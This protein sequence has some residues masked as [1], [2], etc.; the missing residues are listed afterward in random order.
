MG[1]TKEHAA[2]D[3]NERSCAW[4]TNNKANILHQPTAVRAIDWS[5]VHVTVRFLGVDVAEFEL[6]YVSTFLGNEVHSEKG[7]LQSPYEF[8]H[9]GRLLWVS[10]EL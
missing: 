5:C 8:F 3:R 1:R 2:I 6:S 7:L 4:I 10:C 9:E